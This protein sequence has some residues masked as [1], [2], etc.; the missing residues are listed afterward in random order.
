MIL[1]TA[2]TSQ[3]HMLPVS[4]YIHI[5]WC[6]QKCPYCDFNSHKSPDILPE[7]AYVDALLADLDLDLSH[8]PVRGLE[9]IFIGGGTPSLFSA[10][11]YER[12]FKS[13]E[14][15]LFFKPGMEITLE[16]NPGTIDEARFSEYR[17]IGI[18]R[19]SLG[20]QSF[21]PQHLRRLGRI[22]DGRQAHR[23][24]ERARRAGFMQ[25]NLDIM[26]GLPNQTATEGI[27]DL[28]TALSY[29]PEHLSWYQLTIEP[30]TLFYKQQP[31]LP[32]EAI[33]AQ[34]EDEGLALLAAHQFNRYEISAYCRQQNVSFHN[35]NYWLF[36]DYLGIGA[37]A[38]GKWT[39]GNAVLRTRKHRQP[40]DYLENAKPFLA[41]AK[42]IPSQ[43]LL[44][45]FVLNTSRLQQTIPFMLLTER[46][47]LA[48]ETVAPVFKK[49]EAKGL[50]S[51]Q[52]EAWQV[53]ALG[54]RFTNDLQM[55]FIPRF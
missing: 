48:W 54:R 11:A 24:I 37:G 33:L 1:L 31:R 39:M 8:F 45:E 29:Q 17:A 41:A 16:A 36:G 2:P 18:N 42:A 53:T 23:A 40:K 5:P 25:L 50:L 28:K 13:I 15:R 32:E 49:A 38:H 34:L 9:S 21:N 55:M 12:L 27:D 22:H 20:I 30:N 26:H 6:I 52:A 14:S 51:L 43:E 19:L 44:F 7:E 3:H 35:L 47:G 46:T 10:R 4:L